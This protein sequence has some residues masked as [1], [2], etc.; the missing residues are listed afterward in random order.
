MAKG[1]AVT[2]ATLGSHCALQVLKG[3]KDEGFKTLLIC[4]KK[5]A[6]L[7]GR[8]GFI[9]SMIQVDSFNEFLRDGIQGKLKKAN[10]VLVPHGTLISQMSSDQIEKIS[11]P[12]FGNKWILRWEADRALKQRLM[13][14]AGLRTPRP[15]ASKDDIKGLCIVKLHGAAGGKGYYLA[16]DRQSFEEGA[17]RLVSQNMIKGEQDLY[18]QEFIRGVPAYLQ[19]F[20]SPVTKELELLGVDRRYESDIDG[21]GR[22]PARQQ[23][24][25]GSEPSY[26]VVGNIPLVL[27]ESLLDEVYKMGEAFCRAAERLVKPGMPGP[28]CLEGVY[29]SEGRFTTFEFSARIVA[30][31]NLYVDG[32]P[33]SGLLY[34]EPMSMGRRIAREVKIA[35]KKGRLGDVVT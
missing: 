13:E 8:F 31:T 11:T 21:I 1:R 22:I 20:Y 16:W 5:R 18:I 2:I 14:E 19:Y 27:R 35:K 17:S 3:A 34:D 28:F 4:E 6:G 7:Y 24:G 26:T 30:G 29:D 33:Y 9:D 25:A 23:L 15:V 10:A 12:V 32:S